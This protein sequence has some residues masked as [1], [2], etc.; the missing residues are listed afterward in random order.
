MNAFL[1]YGGIAF[2]INFLLLIICLRGFS[3]IYSKR[4]D[5]LTESIK[6]LIQERDAMIQTA[7][8]E[9]DARIGRLNGI[10]GQTIIRDTSLF[11][12]MLEDS[13]SEELEK[14]KAAQVA[15]GIIDEYTSTD[16]D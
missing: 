3:N 8:Q 1:V 4:F 6:E 10:L 12:S 13:D 15:E 11:D 14:A 5:G 16:Q 2:V 7:F 9:R